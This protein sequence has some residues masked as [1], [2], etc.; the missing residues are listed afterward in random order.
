MWGRVEW[1]EGKT[2]SGKMLTTVKFKGKAQCE[3]LGITK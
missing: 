2:K 3:L 1:E